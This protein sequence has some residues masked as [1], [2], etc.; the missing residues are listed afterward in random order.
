MDKVQNK[1][2]SSVQHTPLSESFQVYPD[3]ISVQR[4]SSIYKLHEKKNSVFKAQW[5]Q[6]EYAEYSETS[7]KL[8][9]FFSDSFVVDTEEAN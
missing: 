9:H 6:N 7:A 3:R 4:K 2:N 5:I 1:P 8:L